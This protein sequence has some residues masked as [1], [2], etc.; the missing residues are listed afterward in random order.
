LSVKATQLKAAAGIEVRH[1][2]GRLALAVE[3]AGR[4]GPLPAGEALSQLLATE[5]EKALSPPHE[6]GV[7]PGTLRV[8]LADPSLPAD[9]QMLAS[10]GGLEPADKQMLASVGGLEGEAELV[11][12]ETLFV[13][14]PEAAR[15]MELDLVA[16]APTMG[17]G[18][19]LSLTYGWLLLAALV[20]FALGQALLLLLNRAYVRPVAALQQ[21]TLSV[22]EGRFDTRIAINTGDEL[23]DLARGFSFMQEELVKMRKLSLDANPLTGLPG[24]ATIHRFLEACLGKEDRVAV[25]YVDLDNFKA[26]NDVYGFGRADGLIQFAASILSEATEERD[27]AAFVGHVGGDDFVF[28]VQPEVVQAVA[29]DVI[30]RFDAGISH[31]YSEEDLARGYVIGKDRQHEE[32]N[33]GVA[34]VSMA[35]VVAG[36][37]E[38]RHV[39][40]LLTALAELKNVAKS[41]E[42]SVLLLDR[43]QA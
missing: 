40:A 20:T 38:F 13:D 35:C 5:L 17:I 34:A 32:Q 14:D 30:A 8:T 6:S 22:S 31:F 2:S 26:Y 10:V 4:P 12:R 28:A 41:R 18:G 24:N 15:P 42:G 23:Q 25:V 1:V 43:R 37:R 39:A 7:R 9:K 11:S 36:S 19:L 21:A 29:D 33:Y 16:A 27:H 3:R